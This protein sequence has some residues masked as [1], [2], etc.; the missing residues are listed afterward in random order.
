MKSPTTKSIQSRKWIFMFEL[1]FERESLNMASIASSYHRVLHFVINV[2]NTVPHS[3]PLPAFYLF[4]FS[5]L[6]LHVTHSR[7]GWPKRDVTNPQHTLFSFSYA[8]NVFT[9]SRIFLGFLCIPHSS[10][11]IINNFL[12]F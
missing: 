5:V 11:R 4:F 6:E 7:M 1:F 9:L 3:V 10:Q 2:W 8:C 12:P